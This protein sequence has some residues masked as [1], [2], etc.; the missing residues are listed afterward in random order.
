VSGFTKLRSAFQFSKVHHLGAASLRTKAFVGTKACVMLL[1]WRLAR[2]QKP[3][4]LVLSGRYRGCTSP[5]AHDS[6]R[7]PPAPSRSP[8]RRGARELMLE[9]CGSGQ[10]VL[11]Q[12]LAESFEPVDE[13]FR[14]PS[15][16]T[17]SPA[18]HARDV[19]CGPVWRD[20]LSQYRTARTR[21]CSA[22]NRGEMLPDLHVSAD[23]R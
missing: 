19:V 16:A 11:L 21:P 5:D 14:T 23:S 17:R 1:R 15:I 20:R 18:G 2:C 10:V 6:T 3:V 4:E 12:R 9:V 22:G 7:R 13:A 8:G